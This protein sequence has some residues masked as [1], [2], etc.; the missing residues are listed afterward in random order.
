MAQ[1]VVSYSGLNGS[2]SGGETQSWSSVE[3][4]ETNSGN[5]VTP[6]SSLHEI[7]TDDTTISMTGLTVTWRLIMYLPVAPFELDLGGGGV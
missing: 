4:A 5:P 2:A 6:Q 3:S 1:M 7:T